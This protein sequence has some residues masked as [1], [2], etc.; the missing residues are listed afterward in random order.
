MLSDEQRLKRQS[1]KVKIKSL[2]AEAKII[3]AQEQTWGGGFVRTGLHEHRVNNVRKECRAA[4]LAWTFIRGHAYTRQEVECYELPDWDNVLG[5]I[6]RFSGEDE[7]AV[8]Q[9][10]SQWLAEARAALKFYPMGRPEGGS[11]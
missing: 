7:R 5:I 11:A 1:L 2:A 9:R 3:K 10:Y 6:V 8:R 4:L